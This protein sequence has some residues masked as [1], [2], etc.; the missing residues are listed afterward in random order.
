MRATG[1]NAFMVHAANSRT[2]LISDDSIPGKFEL[3][4]TFR[5]D[6][7]AGTAH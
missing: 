5:P 2:N 3:S 7:R 6:G 4:R 1:V